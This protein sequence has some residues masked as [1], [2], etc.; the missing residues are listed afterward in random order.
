[1]LNFSEL[2]PCSNQARMAHTLDGMWKFRFDPEEKGLQEGWQHK[3][4][5]PILHAGSRQ[6][7]RFLYNKRGEGFLRRLL[8]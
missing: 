5:D 1:M 2:Y 4:P 8:V 6:F 3:L 7:F